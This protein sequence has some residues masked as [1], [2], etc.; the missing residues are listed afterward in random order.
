MTLIGSD[1][2]IALM[3]ALFVIA[4]GAFLAER[5]RIGSHLTGAV[6]TIVGAASSTS[7]TTVGRGVTGHNSSCFG[8]GVIDGWQRIGP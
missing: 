5:T 7:S 8:N 3:A 6:Q 1:N 2:S 4:G